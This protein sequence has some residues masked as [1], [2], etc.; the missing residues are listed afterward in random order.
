MIAPW[1]QT[2]ERL[3]EHKV[4]MRLITYLNLGR[5]YL[6]L[7]D[8][9]AAV[10]TFD[11]AWHEAVDR[12]RYDIAATAARQRAHIAR[13]QGRLYDAAAICREGLRDIAEP[14]E[15]TG[16]RP[17]APGILYISLG[18]V[19]LEQG[20]REDA[21][22]LLAK[23]LEQIGGV[24]RY[25]DRAEGYAAL[26]RLKQI[27]GYV[28]DALRF[29]D[30]VEASWPEAQS[31][32][33]A[34]ALRVRLWTALSQRDPPLLAQA[35]TWA[36][37]IGHGFDAGDGVLAIADEWRYT[38]GLAL[39]RL[40]I[41]RC[42]LRGEPDV[43]PVLDY[44]ERHLQI[45]EACGLYE[46]AIELLILQALALDAQGETTRALD[47]LRRALSLAELEGY[48][49]IFTDEGTP[50]ARLL[51]RVAAQGFFPDYVG[52]LLAAFEPE[53]R[54]TGVLA[55][56]S[57]PAVASLVEPLSARE[58]QVLQLIAEGLTN[59][60]I[61]QRLFISPKTVKRHASSIYDK[62]DV[63]SRTQAAARARTLGILSS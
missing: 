4:G 27:E 55:K 5:G 40:H 63:H 46:C 36:R 50:M 16:Q 58:L 47:D 6:S 12:G 18:C 42:R 29:L 39:V 24:G 17:S 61:A 9:S 41:A 30:Q 34:A 37:R 45:H 62:L 60:E 3:P 59:Q 32:A 21:G 1:L 22:R 57:D 28:T 11:Q 31:D 52:R 38:C 51:S 19:L 15:Q 43:Q 26:A 25:A 54:G 13:R 48:F 53:A 33:Y 35:T 44:L 56:A 49:H 8:L 23:G 7:G 14:V 20:E 10:Q 2:L